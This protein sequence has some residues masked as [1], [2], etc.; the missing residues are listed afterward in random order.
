[1]EN[2]YICL[3]VKSLS[4]ARLNLDENSKFGRNFKVDKI[5]DFGRMKNDILD[6]MFV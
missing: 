1:M 6:S 2:Q 5:G 4:V 3:Q